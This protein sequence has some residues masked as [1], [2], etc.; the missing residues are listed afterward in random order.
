MTAAELLQKVAILHQ[1]GAQWPEIWESLNPDKNNEVERLLSEL[2]GPHLFAPEVGLNVIEDGCR[3]AIRVN[4]NA[5]RTAALKAAL[6]S[7][8]PFVRPE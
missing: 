5:D 6:N 8:D 1:I 2:R 4:P 3:R 7:G